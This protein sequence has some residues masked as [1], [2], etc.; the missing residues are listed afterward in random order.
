M[1][2]ASMTIQE[3]APSSLVANVGNRQT[4]S[5]SQLTPQASSQGL[6]A[7]TFAGSTAIVPGRAVLAIGVALA[8]SSAAWSVFLDVAVPIALA[9]GCCTLAAVVCTYAA[10][11]VILNFKADGV[12]SFVPSE[13][14]SMP[15][16]AWQLVARFRISDASRLW[17]DIE[18]GSQASQETLAWTH[19][20]MDAIKRGELPVSPQMG[21]AKFRERERANPS[22]RTEIERDDLAVWAKG[23]GRTPRFLHK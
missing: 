22:W 19:A 3:S 4:P 9:A 20:M 21:D 7:R 13:S 10:L 14:K 12:S 11:L 2:K 1:V 15:S 8:V 5:P 18:P 16:V 23:H 6:L 17:C